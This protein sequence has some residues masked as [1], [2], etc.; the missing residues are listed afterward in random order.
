MFCVVRKNFFLLSLSI[1][2]SL[3]Y[4]HDTDKKNV[5]AL[6]LCVFVLI[7]LAIYVNGKW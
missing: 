7:W 5:Y 4:A 1:S 3:N 2:S 6:R